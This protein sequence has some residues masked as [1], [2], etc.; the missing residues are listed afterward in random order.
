MR[1]DLLLLG[2]TASG[3]PCEARVSVHA[4]S[5]QGLQDEAHR[6]AENGPWY[7]R[8]ASAA[9]VSENESITVERVK[10]LNKPP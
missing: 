4:N 7:Y 6:A 2:R 5:Q 3:K 10:L 1:F 9:A 8:D